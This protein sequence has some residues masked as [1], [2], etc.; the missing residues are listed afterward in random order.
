[1]VDI[2]S[3]ILRT[4]APPTGLDAHFLS[5]LVHA[6]VE[7]HCKVQELFQPMPERVHY[8]FTMRHLAAVFRYTAALMDG[9]RGGEEEEVGRRKGE[10]REMWKGEERGWSNR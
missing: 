1:M 10:E 4:L 3:H 6:A 7:V 9:G 2:F 8:L 5:Q